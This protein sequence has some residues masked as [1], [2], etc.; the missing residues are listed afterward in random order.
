MRLSTW[1]LSGGGCRRGRS[2]DGCRR[3]LRVAWAS[4]AQLFSEGL[5]G[6]KHDI[7]CLILS[8]AG[9]LKAGAGWRTGTKL[10]DTS[11]C[12]LPARLDYAQ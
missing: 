7:G 6:F 8:T 12:R 11:S 5:V 4:D 2:C 10:H 3:N 9:D 1:S